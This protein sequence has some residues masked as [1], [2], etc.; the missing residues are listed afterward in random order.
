MKGMMD[1]G[2]KPAM[3]A[4]PMPAQYQAM[5]PAPKPAAAKPAKSGKRR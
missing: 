5:H 1:K 4:H 2:K 3:S